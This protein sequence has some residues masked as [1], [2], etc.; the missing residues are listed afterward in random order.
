MVVVRTSGY[1]ELSRPYLCGTD[2]ASDNALHGYIHIG[3][4][5]QD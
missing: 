2:T 4:A 1:C 5:T 3:L